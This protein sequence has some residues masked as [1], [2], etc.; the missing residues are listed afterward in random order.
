MPVN[1]CDANKCCFA[2]R[3]IESAFT[4]I[5]CMAKK[6]C[7][8]QSI[9]LIPNKENLERHASVRVNKWC[10]RLCPHNM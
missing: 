2:G 4:G 9:M 10:C 3:N 6:F 8:N 7:A 1:G 5:V